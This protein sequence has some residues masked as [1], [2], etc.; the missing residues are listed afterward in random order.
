M[1]RI[2]IEKLQWLSPFENTVWDGLKTPVTR[3]E[4]AEAVQEGRLLS[5]PYR[6]SWRRKD[7]I[8]RIAFMVVNPDP[9]PLDFDVGVPELG[10]Y[11][12]WPLHDGHH[13]LAAAIFRGDEAIEA[14]ICGSLDY[15]DHLFCTKVPRTHRERVLEAVRRYPGKTSL[16]LTGFLDGVKRS[17]VATSLK[18]LQATRLVRTDREGPRRSKRYWEAA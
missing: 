16:E 1:P 17:T 12:D 18:R 4:V 10:C 9:K 11:V 8:E 5:E 13:R 3:R 15:A 14:D 6:A 7:H 2:L